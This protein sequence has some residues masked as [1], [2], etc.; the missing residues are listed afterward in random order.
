VTRNEDDDNNNNNRNADR[1]NL[2]NFN[3][4]ITH[5]LIMHSV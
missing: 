5:V 3:K 1:T 4:L 2:L